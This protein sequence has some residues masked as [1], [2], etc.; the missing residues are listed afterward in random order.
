[1]LCVKMELESSVADVKR[2]ILLFFV[3]KSSYFP[4][5]SAAWKYVALYAL[6]IASVIT[7]YNYPYQG[8]ELCGFVKLIDE[9]K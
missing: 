1:M 6:F 9:G 8:D 5:R 4:G 3:Y 2:D 7:V